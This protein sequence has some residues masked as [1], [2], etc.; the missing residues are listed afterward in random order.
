MTDIASTS[1][2]RWIARICCQSSTDS[3]KEAPSESA[4]VPTMTAAA[5]KARVMI[6]MMIKMRQRDEIAAIRRSHWAPSEMSWKT[7]AVPAR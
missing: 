6:S 4:T 7:A 3:P 2:C 5:I 1:Q